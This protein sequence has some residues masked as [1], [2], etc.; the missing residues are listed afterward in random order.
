MSDTPAGGTNI[1]G[2]SGNVSGQY[3]VGTHIQQTMKLGVPTD[4][5]TEG[6]LA[7]LRRTLDELRA[8]IAQDAPSPEVAAAA[9]ERVTELEEAVRGG[10]DGPDLTTMAYVK[11]WFGKNLP[12]LAGAVVSVVIHPV[13][14]K[15]VTAAGDSAVAEFKRH[16]GG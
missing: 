11:R 6:E 14:G 4:P 9:S 15:L 12:A 10:K 5:P 7:D 16:F 3:A 8:Q 2:T 13:V 1:S